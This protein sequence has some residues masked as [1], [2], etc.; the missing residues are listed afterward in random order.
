[1]DGSKTLNLHA[2]LY[3]HAVE[4]EKGGQIGSRQGERERESEGHKQRLLEEVESQRLG[5]RF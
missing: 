2:S 5:P 4:R 3:Y 1:M